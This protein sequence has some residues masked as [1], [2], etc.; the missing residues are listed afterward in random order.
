M[1]FSIEKPIGLNNKINYFKN[2]FKYKNLNGKKFHLFSSS[3]LKIC[4]TVGIVAY[5]SELKIEIGQERSNKN[6]LT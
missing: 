4:V 1:K 6:S 5:Q 3:E 2:L